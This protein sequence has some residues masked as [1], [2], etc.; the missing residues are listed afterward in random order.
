MGIEAKVLI[1]GVR[2]GE[3][4]L[5]QTY[6]NALEDTEF[7]VLK[8]YQ[9]EIESDKNLLQSLYDNSDSIVLAGGVDWDPAL[10]DE[11]RHPKTQ[12]PNSKLDATEQWLIMQCFR[13]KK[14]ILG[15]CRGFQGMAIALRRIETNR[16]GSSEIAPPALVQHLPDTTQIIHEVSTY[17]D[18]WNS[19]HP[20]LV[21]P[22]TR[23]YNIFHMQRIENMPTGHHQA[24]NPDVVPFLPFFHVSSMSLDGILEA[25]ELQRSVHP[26]FLGV[27]GHPEIDVSLYKPLLSEFY[28]EAIRHKARKH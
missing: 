6:I 12:E 11:K 5:R 24:V 8:G 4:A 19:R 1:A 21:V 18:L 20:V 13:D 16:G 7:S 9:D 2:E 15:I 27:Q 26:F 23:L 28:N 22:G 25:G 14:P 17:E 3:Y 10:Y